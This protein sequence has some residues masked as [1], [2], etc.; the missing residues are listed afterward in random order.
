ME[1]VTKIS[2]RFATKIN[3]KQSSSL[4]TVSGSPLM[5]FLHKNVS[6]VVQHRKTT[7]KQRKK[8]E[9]NFQQHFSETNTLC[10]LLRVHSRKV[11][12]FHS[13]E[14]KKT[15][16]KIHWKNGLH[17]NGICFDLKFVDCTL[18]AVLE[19]DKLMRFGVYYMKLM[20]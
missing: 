9:I 6:Q 4:T 18:A 13:F 12:N 5:K 3:N 17:Y 20:S 2:T 8:A 1:I 19:N 15:N 7:Q 16:S 11:I 14:K 10:D